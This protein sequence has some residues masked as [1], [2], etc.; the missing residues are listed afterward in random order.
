MPWISGRPF[1]TFPLPRCKRISKSILDSECENLDLIKW[2]W[3]NLENAILK[4][5]F[6]TIFSYIQALTQTCKVQMILKNIQTGA[7]SE[8]FNLGVFPSMPETK[9]Q[10]SCFAPLGSRFLAQLNPSDSRPRSTCSTRCRSST[11][12][13]ICAYRPLELKQL[14]VTIMVVRVPW[15]LPLVYFLY[16][17]CRAVIR[18]VSW[19]CTLWY[20]ISIQYNHPEKPK[21]IGCLQTRIHQYHMSC[22]AIFNANHVQWAWHCEQRVGLD[23]WIIQKTEQKDEK[24]LL[25]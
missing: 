25:V 19:T 17:L 21:G 7:T 9:S 6:C 14:P 15:S 3:N 2:T 8:M 18:I 23:C 5:L 13:P 20:G 24:E 11:E 1:K 12:L 10:I 16:F 22:A 4:V